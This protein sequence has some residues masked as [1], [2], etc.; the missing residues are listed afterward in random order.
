[1]RRSGVRASA[2]PPRRAVA[3]CIVPRRA[4]MMVPDGI[5]K[6]LLAVVQAGACRFGSSA[7]WVGS[8]CVALSTAAQTL[9]MTNIKCPSV[10]FAV[11]IA[12][13]SAHGVCWAGGSSGVRRLGPKDDAFLGTHLTVKHVADFFRHGLG[14]MR[15]RQ[16]N[17]AT[18]GHHKVNHGSPHLAH[19]RA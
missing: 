11:Q 6:V 2:I 17:P 9:M 13:S 15:L 18:C 7:T 5:L 3:L 8:R 12:S 14:S 16:L 19:H 1:M 4:V 10:R